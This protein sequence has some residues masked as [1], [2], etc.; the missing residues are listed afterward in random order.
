[1]PIKKRRACHNETP[2]TTAC[3]RPESH[4]PSC[5]RSF[6]CERESRVLGS[7]LRRL[8]ATSASVLRRC[9]FAVL[10][11][12]LGASTGSC[13]DEEGDDRLLGLTV[14]PEQIAEA[15]R[16]G[17]SVA[18]ANALGMRFVL[19]PAGT[20]KMGSPGTECGRSPGEDL[21]EVVLTKPFYLQV[22]EVTNRQYRMF[23]AEHK[24]G[25]YEGHSLD[26]A[27]QPVAGVSWSEAKAFADWMSEND[28]DRTYRLPTEAEWE[29]ACR[30]GTETIFSW[31]DAEAD[32]GGYANVADRAARR[33]VPAWV[34]VVDSDD[35]SFVA[36][37][38]GTY[39]P[40]AWAVYDMHGNVWEWCGDWY[41][42]YG[43]GRTVDPTGPGHY[44][45]SSLRRVLRGGSW[46]Y[47]ARHARSA[48]RAFSDF[49]DSGPNDRGF[50]LAAPIVAAQESCRASRCPSDDTD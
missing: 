1:M 16:H 47:S 10:I 20:F 32:A 7:V 50:R 18:F 29:Y 30:A 40:N 41:G 39:Q 27:E 21:H 44:G 33:A 37:T 8:P 22:T 15:R 2:L 28:S 23:Q 3:V 13:G 46:A 48:N 26:E 43:A 49:S 35:R 6:A 17:V 5:P 36:A 9:R 25:A 14:A 38:V 34:A 11:V 12:L 19:V 24:S 45:L 31:G 4:L 42:G